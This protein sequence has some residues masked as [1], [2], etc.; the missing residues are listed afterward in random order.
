MKVKP[1][2]R[3]FRLPTRIA[4]KPDIIDLKETMEQGYFVAVHPSRVKGSDCIG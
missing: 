4:S 3:N 2:D 1:T